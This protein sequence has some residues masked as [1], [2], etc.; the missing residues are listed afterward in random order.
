MYEGK[1]FAAGE[2][3][4]WVTDP[5]NTKV[6]REEVGPLESIIAVPAILKRLRADVRNG[7][8]TYLENLA[9]GNPDKINLDLFKKAIAQEDLY[10]INVLDEIAK[11]LG[12]VIATICIFLDLEL[13]II[14]GKIISLDDYFLEPLKA[15]VDRLTPL[16]TNVVFSKLGN[17]SGIYG[18]F[19]VA[20]EYVFTHLYD[21]KLRNQ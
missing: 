11:Y 5:V 10:C 20:L 16:Q 18:C 15:T 8:K 6:K 14:G 4:Y 17:R 9:C 13:V 12:W 2:I 7:E 21:P 19:A 3:G 1:R